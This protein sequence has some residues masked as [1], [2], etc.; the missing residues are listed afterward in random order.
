MMCVK[1]VHRLG[2]GQG[3]H[4][5]QAIEHGE[6][7]AARS[8]PAA[9]QLADN[10]RMGD[11]LAA[12]KQ[13]DE[14]RAAA[15]KMVDPYRRVDEDHATLRGTLRRRGVTR[16]CGSVPPSRARRRAC[17][18]AISASRPARTSAVFSP[19]LVSRSAS[20]RRSSSILRVVFICTNMYESYR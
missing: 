10:K 3:W 4:G 8:H 9:R 20:A 7:L 13:R 15:T 19:M 14:R 16:S 5:W 17:S 6:D 1:E 11:D 18:R 2:V 12:L